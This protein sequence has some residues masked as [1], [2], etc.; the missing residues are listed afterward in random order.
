MFELLLQKLR[1]NES[2]EPASSIILDSSDSLTPETFYDVLEDEDKE[3]VISCGEN[4]VRYINDV[5][6]EAYSE[7]STISDDD[8]ETYYAAEADEGNENIGEC[9][10]EV[11]SMKSNGFSQFIN[12]D[13]VHPQLNFKLADAIIIILEFFLR[14]HLTWVALDNLLELFHKILGDESRLPKTKYFFK[15]ILGGKQSAIFHFYCQNCGLYIDTFENLNTENGFQKTGQIQACSNCQHPFS[16]NKMNNGHFF[17]QLPLREQILKKLLRNPEILNLDTKSDPD[18]IRDVFDGT[19]YKSLKQKVNNE[20]LV[21]LTVNTDGVKVFKSK[22]Q[23]SLWPIQMI[24][25]E[26]PASRRFK[27]ENIILSGFWFGNTPDFDIYF[28]PFS[29]ELNDLDEDK[30]QVA[31]NNTIY[32]IVLR[33]LLITADTVARCKLL[34]FKQF[35]GAF[36]CTYCLHPGAKIADSNSHKYPVGESDYCRRTHSNSINLMKLAL[37]TGECIC[38]VK[39]ISS[40]IAFKNYDLIRGT[41]ID[42][43]HCV[44]EGVVRLLLDLWFDSENHFHKYYVTP[45]MEEIVN[46][47][48]NCIKGLRSFT[49][50]PRST[51]EKGFW[52]ANEFRCWLLYY[53]LPCLKGVLKD[54]YFQHFALL[55][56]AIFIFLQT[57]I[58]KT[59][60]DKAARN[61]QEFVKN[62]A[63]LYG[64]ENMMYNVHLLEHLSECVTSCGP[65]WAYSNFNFESNNG[66]LVQNV[67]GTTDVEKQ[68]ATRYFY[69]GVLEDLKDDYDYA[70]SY[71]DEIKSGRI[72]NS[73][74]FGLITLLGTSQKL[75]LNSDEQRILQQKWIWDYKKFFFSHDVFYSTSYR[76]SADREIQTNDTVAILKNGSIGQIT[77]IYIRDEVV[78]VLLEKLCVESAAFFP[79]HI[80][81]VSVKSRILESVRADEIAEKMVLI[82]T[83]KDTYV[84]HLPNRIECD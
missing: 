22:S 58:S 72:R 80:K 11:P 25:N 1:L 6:K 28:K 2:S 42:Y 26:I 70:R 69:Y 31:A 24:I 38:G 23:S 10:E 51:K 19:L 63:K 56:E 75:N 66:W 52:K 65:L 12:N 54:S 21:T 5:P 53:A 30:L 49:R 41:V 40:L 67:K 55:S 60:F 36:G 9:E 15:K 45:R 39:G 71:I 82:S 48:L 62:F 8:A 68:L 44:L 35:N 78:Y 13:F 17:I 64:E 76:S 43:M 32:K 3:K 29:D 57:N 50:R 83:A 7:E 33:V 47:N 84:S 20:K 27:K 79:R 14:H 18:N 37:K 59:E 4:D 61:L 81:K 34:M 74:K 73:R 16:L 77:R 46:K